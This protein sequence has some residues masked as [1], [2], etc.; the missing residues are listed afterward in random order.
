MIAEIIF[1]LFIC[2][3]LKFML[4]LS[5]M[6]ALMNL[7]NIKCIIVDF[8]LTLYSD[9]NLSDTNKFYANFLFEHKLYEQTENAIVKL[10]ELY[11]NFHMIQCI[12]HLARQKGIDDEYT[13]NWL[14]KNIY[15]IMS[16]NIRIVSKSLIEKLCKKYPV[17]ILSDSG[18]GYLKYYLKKFGYDFDWFAGVI[19]NDY[20]SE[21][22]GKSDLMIKIVNSQNLQTDEVIMIGDSQ[23]ADINA[24]DKAG[25]L[26]YLVRDISDTE[27]VF[28]QLLELRN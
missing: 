8:D 26:S 12:F 23:K 22:M 20:K 24:A 18:Q 2:E 4:I 3:Y 28:Q 16:E 11:P 1:N 13:K 25:I 10:K 17:Y 9:A 19:S 15:N 14:D 5:C 21:D 27:K 6:E 7:E